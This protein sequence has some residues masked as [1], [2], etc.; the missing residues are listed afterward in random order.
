MGLNYD[1]IVVGDYSINLIFT[2][3]PGMPEVEKD[4]RA[5]GFDMG[6]GYFVGEQDILARL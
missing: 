1:V 2:G 6:T 4:L 5:G 3:L